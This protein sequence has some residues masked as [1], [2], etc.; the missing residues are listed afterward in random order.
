MAGTRDKQSYF[1]CL[2]QIW[3]NKGQKQDSAKLGDNSCG[4]HSP[5][6]SNFFLVDAS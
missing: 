2:E 4:T 3:V 6:I 5:T 1:S